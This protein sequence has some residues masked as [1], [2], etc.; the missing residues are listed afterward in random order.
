MTNK[1]PD[2]LLVDLIGKLNLTTVESAIIKIDK[3][4]SDECRSLSLGVDGLIDI[5]SEMIGCL[6][7]VSAATI[8][9]HKIITI[10]CTNPKVLHFLEFSCHKNL[11]D[12]H[13]TTSYESS[14]HVYL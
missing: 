4:F 5:D 11:L 13:E 10:R 6:Y 1:H 12:I 2:I 8:G 14:H 7:V 9:L 3:L